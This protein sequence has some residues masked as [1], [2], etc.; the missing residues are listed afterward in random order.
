MLKK[1]H[2]NHKNQRT[3]I[4]PLTGKTETIVG[5]KAGKMR[6]KR[7]FSDPLRTHDRGNR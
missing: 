7:K 6:T 3:I 5:T 1:F 4:N 2:S